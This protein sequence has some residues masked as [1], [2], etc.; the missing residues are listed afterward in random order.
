M[1]KQGKKWHFYTDRDQDLRRVEDRAVA[2]IALLDLVDVEVLGQ[3]SRRAE[4][5]RVAEHRAHVAVG[6]VG[7]LERVA[8]EQTRFDVF[9]RIE[10]PRERPGAERRVAHL[11]LLVVRHEVRTQR[12][13]DLGTA[14]ER[15]ERGRSQNG[16]GAEHAAE[17]IAMLHKIGCNY[18]KSPLPQATG[19]RAS[20]CRLRGRSPIPSGRHPGMPRPH[21]R[22]TP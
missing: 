6:D 12:V 13:V 9:G 7:R 20:A 22:H 5:E 2:E 11:H 8:L 10:F 21:R 16:G 4:S 18:R 17:I 15:H 3:E 19:I 14:R 1:K